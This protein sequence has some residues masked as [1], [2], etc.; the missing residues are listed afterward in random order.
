MLMCA[1]LQTWLNELSLMAI[2]RLEAWS[3]RT[4]LLSALFKDVIEMLILV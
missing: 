2:R 3:R 4:A 1:D